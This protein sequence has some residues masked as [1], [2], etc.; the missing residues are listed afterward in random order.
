MATRKLTNLTLKRKIKLIGE[1]ETKTK[2]QKDV[3]AEFDV[4]ANSLHHY[5]KEGPLSGP[6]LFWPD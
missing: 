5:E 4:P 2:K 1:V 3:T 6:I